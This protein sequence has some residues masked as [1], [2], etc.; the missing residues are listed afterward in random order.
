MFIAM[1]MDGLDGRVARLTHTQTD[2][3]AEYDSLA[4]MVSF[5][6]APAL[7]MFEWTLSGLGKIGWMA[8]FIYTAGTAL[9]LARFNTQAGTADKRYFQG[10]PSPAAA[11]LLAGL[12]WVGD[13]LGLNQVDM[14]IPA[15]VVTLFAGLL[16][17]SN[18][19]YHS[20]KEIDF[21]GKVSFIVI[22]VVMIGFA[23]INMQ[24]PL[25]LF[26]LFAIYACSGP[27]VTLVQLRRTRAARRRESKPDDPL[28]R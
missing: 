21:R 6:L 27:V 17:V 24:P 4:D 3:G 15:M 7:V 20:F 18:V 2:F 5:G 25:A 23:V 13:D 9:R 10:L 16:M 28:D 19:R 26:S 22:V 1:L 8:A 14:A 12:V 11:G